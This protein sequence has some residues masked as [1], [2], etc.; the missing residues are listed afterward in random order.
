[1]LKWAR[2]NTAALRDTT[3]TQPSH[4]TIPPRQ[5][6]VAQLE[7]NSN[8]TSL[9]PKSMKRRFDQYEPQNSESIKRPRSG[10]LIESSQSLQ[11]IQRAEFA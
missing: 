5:R 1:M 7:E 11:L 10:F 3:I 2:W 8:I 9:Q 4:V 6:G